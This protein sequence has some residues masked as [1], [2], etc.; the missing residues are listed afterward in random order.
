M[1]KNPNLSL[2][3]IGI[4]SVLSIFAVF[5]VVGFAASPPLLFNDTFEASSSIN[6][7]RWTVNS[8]V[9]ITT[10]VTLVHSGI[11]AVLFNGSGA[12]DALLTANVNTVGYSNITLSYWRRAVELEAGESFDVQYSVDGGSS[13]TTIESVGGNTSY[14]QTIFSFPASSN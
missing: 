4:L 11:R 6:T 10:I 5:S 3:N 13:W 2:F 8:T 14:A 9:S 12:D 7:T 1:K